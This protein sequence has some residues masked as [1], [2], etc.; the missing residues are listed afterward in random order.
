MFKDLI[1][2]LKKLFLYFFIFI[3]FFSCNRASEIK[4]VLPVE[5]PFSI[6]GNWIFIKLKINNSDSLHFIVDT[7]VDE[8]I[9]SKKKAE[10]LHLKFNKKALFSGAFGGDSVAYS[11]NNIITIGNCK[12]DSII[13]VQ[14]PLENLEQ[15]F[16]VAVDGLIGEALFKKYIVHINFSKST[17]Q[18]SNNINDFIKNDSFVPLKIEIIEKVP[19]VNASFIINGNDTIRAK[20]M[21]DIGFRNSIAFCSP[22]INRYQLYA[23]LKKFYTFNATGLLSEEKS[24]MA[25]LNSLFLGPYKMDSIPFMLTNSVSGT[26]SSVSYDGIIGMDVLLRF[27][28]LCF[29]YK[30]NTLFLGRYSFVADTLFSDVNCSGLELKKNADKT[31]IVNAVYDNSPASEAGLKAKDELVFIQG[32]NIAELELTE[33]K[34]ILRMKGK[35][36]ELI[37]RRSNLIKHFEIN[38]REL[39]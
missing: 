14:V 17:I 9:I 6:S 21:I 15:T 12:L 26:L 2:S 25:R 3:A 29:D 8:T 38:L 31:V 1:W 10:E 27:R 33:I 30:N 4:N 16:G 34:K 28:S 35:T 13:L 24:Y 23:K 32:K 22:F 36:I 39:I 11:E 20:C 7:G 18:L 19:I 37:V 5:I